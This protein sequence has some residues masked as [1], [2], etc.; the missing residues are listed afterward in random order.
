MLE[1]FSL[2]HVSSAY[3]CWGVFKTIVWYYFC[4]LLIFVAEKS[5][6]GTELH[7]L[8]KQGTLQGGRTED[9]RRMFPRHLHLL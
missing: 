7:F 8:C 2:I 4:S 5:T 9:H 6:K 1:I 3:H